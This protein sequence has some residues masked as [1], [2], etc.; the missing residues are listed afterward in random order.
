MA[1]VGAGLLGVTLGVIGARAYVDSITEVRREALEDVA[2]LAHELNVA[3]HVRHAFFL[4]VCVC[5][6]VEG[7]TFQGLQAGG[8]EEKDIK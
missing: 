5:V 6:Y 8:R 2:D 3:V 1:F 7:T 4:C